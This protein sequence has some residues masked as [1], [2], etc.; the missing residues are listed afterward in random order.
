MTSTKPNLR[1]HVVHD[2]TERR[3]DIP[4]DVP[5]ETRAQRRA[6][7]R[8]IQKFIATLPKQLTLYPRADWP[9]YLRTHQAP[10]DEVWRSRAFLV[11]IRYKPKDGLGG[12]AEMM[13]I[14]RTIHGAPITWDE[15]QVIKRDVGR[16]DR[17]AVEVYPEDRHL[18]DVAEMRHLWILAERPAFAW[19]RQTQVVAVNLDD[20]DA[21]L[22]SEGHK[23]QPP[24]MPYDYLALPK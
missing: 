3:Y 1:R 23:V 4:A 17:C 16:G 22:I 9:D 18:V 6:Y 10:P 20:I 21:A 13:S 14:R 2:G 15:L 8:D 7:A 24:D 5:Q 12:V 11:Q 19:T